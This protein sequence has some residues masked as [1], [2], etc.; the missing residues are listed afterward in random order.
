MPQKVNTVERRVSDTLPSFHS[1]EGQRV[2]PGK[3]LSSCPSGV[4]QMKEGLLYTI[5]PQHESSKPLE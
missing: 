5:G 2:D 1:Q 4:D 3:W